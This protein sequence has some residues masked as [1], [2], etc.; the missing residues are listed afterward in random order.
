M[1][2][3]GINK[4]IIFKKDEN[5]REIN[6]YEFNNSTLV[7]ETLYYPNLKLYSNKKVYNIIDEQTMSLKNC[8][9]NN[10]NLIHSKT[11]NNIYEYPVFFLC[12]NF[13][14]YFH[15]VYDTIP[16]LISYFKLKKKYPNIKLL[17]NYPNKNMNSFYK[18][19]IEFLN[20]LDININDLIII[21]SNTLYS[22]IFV[23]DSYTHGINSNC[24]P[25]KEIF[26]IY[27]KIKNKAL[28]INSNIKLSKS[29]Y[30]SRNTYDKKNDNMG[31]NYTN[32][33]KLINENELIEYL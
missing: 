26:T 17:V 21:D 8:V 2:L 29:I 6:I 7:G 10:D 28:K 32:R 16:Y 5:N 33:R 4:E 11:T 27:D 12:Y 14:N 20:L 1:K 13:E 23:S 30:I 25:R 3:D 18:F 31:T 24:Y 15:F 19:N 22:K 9:I